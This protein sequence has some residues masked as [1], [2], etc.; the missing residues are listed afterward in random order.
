MGELTQKISS[1]PPAE[2]AE[3]ARA[4]WR[5]AP[6][7]KPI[8]AVLGKMAAGFETCM[9]CGESRGTDVDHF[10][11]IA[12]NP[13]RTFDWLNHL[14]ACS[15]CN[16][17]QK[18][19]RFPVDRDGNPL[20]VDPTAEDPFD[21]LL[22]TLSLGIYSPLTPKGE[23]T[24]A[25]F[26]LNERGLPRGRMHARKVV[27]LALREWD[28]A[29]ACARSDEM[30]EQVRTV[31]DQPFADVCQSMLRQAFSPGADVVFS[32]SPDLLVLLRKPELREALLR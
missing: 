16:S 26:G 18:G 12:R 9:Y 30:Q 6:V 11:P 28:R 25:V 14:L 17:H 1:A 23:A 29:R 13:L 5:S 24:I 20:L 32:D 10:E 15:T 31:Q 3:N 27:G 4:S 22:L 21:H 2:R 19:K 8:R 7:R